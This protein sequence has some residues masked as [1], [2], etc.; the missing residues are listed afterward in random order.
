[1]TITLHDVTKVIKGKTVADH[2]DLT[3]TSGTVY[4]LSGYNGCGKTMLMRLIAGL[5][6]PT[7]GE[8]R[9]GDQILGKDIDF[10]ESVGI[11]IESPAFLDGRSGMD[12]LRLLASIRKKA[13]DEIIAETI[14]RVGLD[15]DDPKKYRKYSL[16]MKQRLGIAAAIM[17]KPDL[18]ILDEPTNALDTDGVRLVKEMIA[19]EKERGALIIITCHDSIMLEEFCDIIY[20]IEHGKI[21]DE[22]K[23][24]C[25]E[26]EK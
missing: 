13:T 6:L 3:F 21:K 25:K 19:E 10:P 14:R 26:T 2:I 5:I 23:M 1:M 9:F 8:I 18:I 15:P 22:Q 4:G 20:G 16:G 11:L 12:N 24:Q 17:E 7:E